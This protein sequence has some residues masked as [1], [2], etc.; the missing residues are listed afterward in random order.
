[1]RL[2][3]GAVPARLLKSVTLLTLDGSTPCEADCAELDRA[4]IARP[5]GSVSS[6]DHGNRKVIAI[7]S[8][9]ERMTF[10]TLY[11]VLGC[12]VRSALAVEL[13]RL[14]TRWVV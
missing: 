6:I 4:G 10:D 12:E 1:M 8:N 13:A 5:V 9:N 11:G 14:E 7:L 2:R 3:Q